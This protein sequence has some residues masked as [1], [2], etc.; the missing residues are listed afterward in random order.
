MGH[1]NLVWKEQWRNRDRVFREHISRQ[2]PEVLIL[3]EV[4]TEHLKIDQGKEKKNI[5]EGYYK[6]KNTCKNLYGKQVALGWCKSNC[7]FALLHFAIW[8]YVLPKRTLHFAIWYW[9]IF[10]N[11]Y[12]YVIHHFNVHFSF[13]FFLLMAY[14]L[15][16]ILY[17][18]YTR[19]MM[20]DTK[21]IW[22]IFLFVFKI[23]HTAAEITCNI[24]NA[25]GPGPANKRTVRC[26]FKKFCK[27]DKSLEDEEC[28]GQPSEVDNN[29]LRT[30][31]KLDPLTTTWEVAEELNI[32]HSIVIW[33]LKQIGKTKKL[34]KRVLHKL[35]ANLKT[36][37]FE[38]LSSSILPN[39]INH[40]LIGLW[41]AT[42]SGFYKTTSDDHLTGWTEKLQSTSQSQTWMKQRSWS[43][44]G[45]LLPVW[46]STA[47]WILT[48]HYI[49]EVCSAN[50]WENCNDYSWYWSTE[51]AQFST[52]RTDST[53]YNQCFKS[54]MN[55]AMKFASSAIFTWPLANYHFFKDL[56]S[57]LQVKCFHNQE[58]EGNP[59]V[60]HLLGLCAS[61]AGGT[62]SISGQRTKISH[63][64]WHLQKKK[65]MHIHCKAPI[66]YQ[67]Q[68]WVL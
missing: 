28:S 35:T 25:F 10:L 63:A 4:H 61:N 46:P 57:F 29:H 45:G 17:L 48:K 65:R 60:V 7:S 43:L 64:L 41:H 40:F 15:M 62:G 59:L 14:Y 18:F 36:H 37:H 66:L 9:N 58:D 27:G 55:W 34:D 26:C 56:N 49:W 39:K 21:Q 8:V 20:S 68:C 2:A 11:K 52:T 6:G 67:A 33:H 31:T 50:W 22:V 51:R 32:D 19:E 5:A 42:K 53:S 38:V 44:F 24:N 12:G 54:W 47:F 16:C 1:F 30:I 3:K 23:G 13:Y